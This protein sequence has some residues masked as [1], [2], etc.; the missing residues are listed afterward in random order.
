MFQRFTSLSQWQVMS[1]FHDKFSQL[2]D[3]ETAFV[4]INSTELPVWQRW[5]QTIILSKEELLESSKLVK[6][7]EWLTWQKILWRKMYNIHSSDPALLKNAT[8]GS[9]PRFLQP[10]VCLHKGF[11]WNIVTCIV[12]DN[13]KTFSKNS[14]ITSL[15]IS[16]SAAVGSV[17]MPLSS[18]RNGSCW[19]A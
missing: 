5:R 3:L 13:L 10:I 7:S 4:E 14:R 8:S 15:V 18:C 19:K 1:P 16:G 11:R 9:S 17:H 2:W 12:K 6:S